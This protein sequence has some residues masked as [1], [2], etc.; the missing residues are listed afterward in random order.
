M[1]R[2]DYGWCRN[3]EK[4]TAHEWRGNDLCCAE[5]HWIAFSSHAPKDKIR[6]SVEIIKGL[7]G[8][9]QLI[10][11]GDGKDHTKNHRYQDAEQYLSQFT[12]RAGGVE[13]PNIASGLAEDTP[14]SPA[15]PAGMVMVPREPTGEMEDAGCQA[16]LDTWPWLGTSLQNI[17]APGAMPPEPITAAFKAMLAAAG[18]ASSVPLGSGTLIE[19]SIEI[20]LLQEITEGV[21]RAVMSGALDSRSMAADAALIIEA[22]LRQG[23]PQPAD[24]PTKGAEH[25]R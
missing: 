12:E 20:D 23:A 5:C 7:M 8:L 19:M 17:G 10:S 15:L 11:H 24:A 6:E 25:E 1:N 21:R 14:V 2:A 13:T 18:P 22:R 16:M 9:V 3:C 4:Q